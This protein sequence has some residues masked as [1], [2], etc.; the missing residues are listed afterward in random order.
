MRRYA[1]AWDE[2]SPLTGPHLDV[3][4]GHGD[5]AG[6]F[7]AT[8]GRP[9]SAVDASAEYAAETMRRY[10]RVDVQVS[11]DGR[12]GYEA[13]AFTS[14]SVLD[15]L[16]HVADEHR[17][18]AEVHRVLAPGGTLVVTVPRRHVFS[19]LDPDNAKFRWPRFHEAVYRARFGAETYERRFV[20]TSDGFV[21]DVAV[22]RGEHTNFRTDDL[23]NLLVMAG[24]E[25]TRVAGA[26]LFWRW[27]Q[28]PALL[29][30]SAARRV[31][32]PAI[33]LDGD[34]FTSPRVAANL[35]VTARWVP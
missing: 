26:N 35:F 28:I 20:D 14:V 30:G 1:F 31:L 27:L 19:W 15:V 9:V 29:G 16:E 2:L 6:P 22:E 10:P 13:G 33:R 34:I 21:G 17:L 32:G 11:E 24:F 8:S 12:F 7:E 5:F 3:G 18:L 4:V 23:L 25:P